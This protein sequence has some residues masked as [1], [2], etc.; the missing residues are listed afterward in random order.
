MTD[1]VIRL[2][3]EISMQIKALKDMKVMAESYGYDIS[4]QLPLR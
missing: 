4:E 1:D 2:R 3:E